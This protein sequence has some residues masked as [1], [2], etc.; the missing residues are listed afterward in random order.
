MILTIAN[1]FLAGFGNT[2]CKMLLGENHFK[3]KQP[4]ELNWDDIDGMFLDADKAISNL[5]QCVI[6]L[7]NEWETS[8]G[9]IE[10]FFPWLSFEDVQKMNV[11]GKGKEGRQDIGEE[12][13]RIIEKY[14]KCDVKVWEWAVERFEEQ[15]MGL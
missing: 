1:P 11:G 3:G 2:L 7:Q 6:G 4:G 15:I 5:G 12:K 10:H 9:M 13:R 8:K 14:N